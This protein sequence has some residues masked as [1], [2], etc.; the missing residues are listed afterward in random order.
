[1]SSIVCNHSAAAA[2]SRGKATGPILAQKLRRDIQ[3]PTGNM[4]AL[5][6]KIE[7]LQSKVRQSRDTIYKSTAINKRQVTATEISHQ[8]RYQQE[9]QT[10]GVQK[11]DLNNRIQFYR[12]MENVF[13]GLTKATPE[14]ISKIFKFYFKKTLPPQVTLQYRLRAADKE[15]SDIRLEIE[16][17]DR[18]INELDQNLYQDPEM[19]ECIYVEDLARLRL[20]QREAKLLA[21]KRSMVS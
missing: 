20:Q 15:L 12:N 4:N 18:M 16:A 17:I 3:I 19:L 5:D 13:F 21:V 7:C 8:S 14:E 10:C 11:K 1:M 6:T 2:P 9:I